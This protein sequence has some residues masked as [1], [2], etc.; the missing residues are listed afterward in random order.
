M[1][2]PMRIALLNSL[3]A[4][5][6]VGGAERVTVDLAHAL[7]ERGHA[8]LVITLSDGSV[9]ASERVDALEVERVRLA[10][11]YWPDPGVDRS[12]A[13]RALW[14][15]RDLYNPTMA[16][17]VGA[18]L[19]RWRPQVLHTH[20]VGGFSGA[21]WTEAA[22]RGAAVV[23]TL[24]DHRLL[25]NNYNMMRAGRVCPSLCPGCA[26][27]MRPKRAI[28]GTLPAVTAVSSYLLGVHTA[29][30]FFRDAATEVV[31]NFASAEG[32]APHAPRTGPLRVGFLGKLH[33]SKG[34]ALVLEAARSLSG[35][36][37]AFHIAGTGA[38]GYRT[39]L[40]AGA[41]DNVTFE[42]FVE[43]SEFL[44][45]VDVL[46][47]PSLVNESSAM[48]LYE[49]MAHGVPVVASARG[50]N[51]ELVDDP[52]T[53]LLFDPDEPGALATA[54]GALAADPGRLGAMSARARARATV[55]RRANAVEAYERVY[56]TALERR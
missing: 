20:N 2:E 53:G 24:H 33:P 27:T 5:F 11:A 37:F 23:H 18:V 6:T 29:H 3:F 47:V 35:S 21:V 41:G 12:R 49:A 8:V 55:F 9:P 51:P 7:Q 52:A 22:R 15:L 34:V 42:G 38:P 17:R 31:Y 40:A 16:R 10:N 30:G 43:S 1:P 4:P 39:E 48:V 50:G 45:R 13:A 25:C 19:A 56:R 36:R 32:A 14:H 28:A 44:P 46:A 54:L 26:L